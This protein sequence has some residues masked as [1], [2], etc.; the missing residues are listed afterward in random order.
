LDDIQKL[1]D[2]PIHE[3]RLTGLFILTYKFEK[4]SNNAQ[5]IIYD[6]YLKNTKAI[7]NW[8][9]VD[10]SAHK[11]VGD[12][13]IDKDRSI[14]YKLAQS[15]N[16]WEQRIAI[17]ATFAFIRNKDFEDCL[18]LAEI[19]LTHK[20]DLIHKAVGW[21]LREVGKKDELVLVSFLNPNYQK[22]PRTMLRYAIEK[23]P[24]NIRKKYLKDMI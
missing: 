8:D 3:H 16:L 13:L 17:V 9:L 12:Y 6:F 19:F 21:M 5:K 23:F 24:E 18:N 14:L 7:N 15:K 4:A 10:C 1:L 11:I 2:S 22:M 20:H